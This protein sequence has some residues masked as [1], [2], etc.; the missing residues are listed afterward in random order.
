MKVDSHLEVDSRPAL[1][2]RTAVFNASHNLANQDVS[3]V[4]TSDAASVSLCIQTLT[5]RLKSVPLSCMRDVPVEYVTL[6]T[7]C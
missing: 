4:K 1:C 5:L 7:S 2:T 6:E 3:D